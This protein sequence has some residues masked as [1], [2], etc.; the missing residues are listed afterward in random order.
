MIAGFFC[1]SLS[2]PLKTFEPIGQIQYLQRFLFVTFGGTRGWVE[3]RD[4]ATLPTV[5]KSS[6]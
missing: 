4:V 5:G 2:P 1:L 6:A 3:E